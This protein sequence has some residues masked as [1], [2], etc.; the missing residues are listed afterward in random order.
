M[1]DEWDLTKVKN[2]EEIIISNT[3]INTRIYPTE[4]TPSDIDQKSFRGQIETNLPKNNRNVAQK[5]NTYNSTGNEE[6]K[7]KSGT[8]LKWQDQTGGQKSL[9]E[10]IVNKIDKI[11]RVTDIPKV[12]SHRQ[13]TIPKPIITCKMP[14]YVPR[15]Q[16]GNLTTTSKGKF[17]I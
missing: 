3:Y 10:V 16:L 11:K 4:E 15:P 2:K 17:N 6:S 13:D 8:R 7:Q 1:S 9:I 12:M 14:T 5:S